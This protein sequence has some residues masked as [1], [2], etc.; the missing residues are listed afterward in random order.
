[1]MSACEIK[2]KGIVQGV[3]F[4]PTV[5]RLVLKHRLCGTIRNTSSGVTLELEGE[6]GSLELFLESL[7]KEA[8]PLA[9]IEEIRTREIA[10]QGFSDFRI[11]ASERENE[12][13]TLI[14]PDIAVCPDCLRELQDPT[15][16]RYRFPF[17]NCTNCGP[18]FTIIED[19]PYDRPKTSMKD[20]PMCPDCEREYHDILDRRYHAQPDCCPDCGPKLSFLNAEGEAVPGNPI[21]LA[22]TALKQGKIV[23][24]KGL[25]GFHLACRCDAPVIAQ[26]LRRRKHRDEKPF[27]LMCRDVETVR[28]ICEV[29]DDEEA[30]L[31][32]ARKPIVLLRK[33][34]PGLEYLSEN[35]FLGVM[36]PYTPL[37]V[38]LLQEAADML[39]MTSANISDT[40]LVRDN[41]EA[42]RT[43]QGIADG[44]LL[45][46]RRIQTRCD[47]SLCWVLDGQEYFARRSRG[48]VPQPVTVP[49]LSRQILACGAEQKASFCLGK[50]EHAFLSQHIGDLKNLETLEHYEGQ[51]RHFERLFDNRPAALACDLHPDYLSSEYAEER[52]E[53]EKIPLIRVQHHHAHMVS[54]MTDNRLS[55]PCI[56]LIWDGTGLGTD[57]QVWG[58][59]CLAGDAKG[60][61]RMGSMRPIPLIGG[62]RAVSEPFR[63]AY[64]L[65]R[66]AG[67]STERIPQEDFL[68]K[69]LDAGLNCP[70]SGG[71]GRL[72][73]GVSA[74]LGIRERCSYEG[75]AAILLEA[76]AGTDDGRFPCVLEHGVFDWR[77]MIR[78]LV[79][80]QEKGVKVPVLAA[81][82]LNTLTETAAGMIR[83][84][85]KQSG[86][87]QAVLS[88]GSFQNQILMRQLHS[89]PDVELYHHRRVSCNDEGIA[90]GQMMIADALLRD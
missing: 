4:R 28:R 55:G 21:A 69:Q 39:I 64:A 40:P 88:G 8:P 89:L 71:M 68:R 48:Y 67:C 81:R 9:V 25:G 79:R 24:V 52:A 73:D 26:G 72:F 18:R 74:I 33:K 19:I 14:S 10:E 61:V 27:A 12:R 83:E 47:D 57:G 35:G 59:E 31:S 90:L 46:N 54:C 63:I 86:I 66:E 75:Q 1:M 65:L 2:I 62:D 82:F 45:H 13:N 23:A 20:F 78:A 60:F 77:E 22:G 36:L 80:E 6:R 38:L 49:E 17:I 34:Q 58:A 87:R 43:L 15:D 70:L 30:I 16:R 41:G 53:R 50:G 32:G 42:V 7:Q 84:A 3:G 44:F 85:S 37:H 51:I 76:C 56:G 5:H 11:L 29:S